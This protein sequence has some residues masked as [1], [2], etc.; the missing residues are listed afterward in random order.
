MNIRTL[1]TD[2]RADVKRFIDFPFKLYHQ[3]PHWVPPLYSEMKLVLNRKQHPFYRHSQAD[4]FVC[5][6]EG[7]ILGRLAILHNQNYSQHHR[8]P[9]G[10]FYYFESVNDPQVPQQLF[11]AGIEWAK[12]RCLSTILGPKGFLRAN[13]AG[14]LVEGFD[15]RPAMGILYNFDYYPQLIEKAGFEKETDHLSG[16]MRRGHNFP[17]RIH[18]AAA[19]VKE[20]GTFWVRHF[21][22]KSEMRAMIQMV[23]KVHHEAFQNNPGFYPSTEA[24][25]ALIANTMIQI[26]DPKLIKVI[27]KEQEI[28]GFILAYADISE[29]LRKIKGRLFPFGWARVLSEKKRSRKVDLNGVGILPKFQG[30]GANLVLYSELEK[31]LKQ[32]PFELAELVQ[33]DERNFKSKSDMENMGVTWYKRHRTY[34]YT[35]T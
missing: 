30:R 32:Y 34:R 6:S 4:F 33:V 12:K 17:E 27:M 35:L 28:A 22:R 11:D 25:F 10:F 5:E 24:E 15:H 14:L 20:Q 2:N 23:D 9:I 19:K 21:N 31:T 7:D 13:G 16:Y 29:A 1:D 3:N 18:Q 26:A 8:S